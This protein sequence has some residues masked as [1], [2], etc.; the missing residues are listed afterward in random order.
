MNIDE[1]SE[2]TCTENNSIAISFGNSLCGDIAGCIQE[3][4]EIG[5]DAITEDGML[6]DI[7]IVST[8]VALYKIGNTIRDRHNLKKLIAFLNGINIGI[9]DE[10]E[11]LNYINEFCSNAKQRNQELE[12]ILVLIDRYISYDKPQML[13][14]LYLAYLRRLINWPQFTMYAEIV[15]RFLPGDCINFLSDNEEILTYNNIGN[16]VF[17]R[18]VAL[19][20]MVEKSSNSLFVNDGRGG[21]AITAESMNKFHQEEKVYIRTDFGKTLREI[22]C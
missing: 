11:R 5:L 3:Y 18:L 7:P 6:K 20:L 4:A 9:C 14:K 15:D 8:A 22:L 21:F 12:Y 17:L 2:V 1:V 16:E 19:G 13:S 10:N